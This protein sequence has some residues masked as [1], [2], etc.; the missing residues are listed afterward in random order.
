[1]NSVRNTVDITLT[2]PA[3]YDLIGAAELILR[4][5]GPRAISVLSTPRQ[6]P[7]GRWI[8]PKLSANDAYVALEEACRKVARVAI[9]KARLCPDLPF[10]G[11]LGVIFPD[12]VAYLAR[13]VK[14]V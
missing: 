8:Q 10:E 13:A 3:E 9:R 11:A 2:A 7:D 4:E 6:M 5:Y 12:P 14:S 1:M